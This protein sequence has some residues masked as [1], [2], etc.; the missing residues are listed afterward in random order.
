M[1]GPI[2]RAMQVTLHSHVV[3]GADLVLNRSMLLCKLRQ[4]LPDAMLLMLSASMT[5]RMR[6]QTA[7]ALPI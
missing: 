6:P 7:A 1:S 5:F 3:Q 2:L 4:D